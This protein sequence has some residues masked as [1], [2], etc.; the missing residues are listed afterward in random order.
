MSAKEK[1]KRGFVWLPEFVEDGEPR[2]MGWRW[3]TFGWYRWV[4]SKYG[5]E[6]WRPATHNW[7]EDPRPPAAGGGC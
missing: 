3:L 6:Y 7:D 4:D 1:W 2:K 5:P